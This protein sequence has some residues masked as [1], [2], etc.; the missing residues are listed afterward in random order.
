M[1]PRRFLAAALLWGMAAT[2]TLAQGQPAAKA[3]NQDARFDN[4][5]NA[6]T[7][8][9][10]DQKLDA[11]L[12]LDARFRDENGQSVTLGSYFGK[13]PVLMVM[14][15]YRCT[16][17]CVAML[18]GISEALRD[19]GLR[20]QV[21]R[22]FTIVTISINP[23]ETADLAASK[24][25]TYLSELG[26]P[27]ADQGWHFLTGDENEIRRVAD[28]AGY[29]YVYDASRDQYAHASGIWLSTPK[30]KISRYF[31]GV[32]YPT[33]DLRLALTESGRGKIGTL[34]DQMILFCY[35][36]DPQRNQYGLAVFR[37][38]QVFG[39]A[40]VL[41][42]ALFILGNLRKERQEQKG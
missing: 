32:V 10:L 36:Y 5:I 38:I 22:D 41:S 6:A 9:R 11:Q 35:H 7:D 15:F 20:F 31:Y 21:G 2:G 25:K 13:K 3:F 18:N 14:P 37:L 8:V 42:I 4:G 19:P 33:K 1:N 29:K 27:G 23:K 34:A 28:T 40:T 16:G 17:T 12:P 39:T 24:K 30:G 26:I